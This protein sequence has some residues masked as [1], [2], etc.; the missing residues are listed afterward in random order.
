M[1]APEPLTKEQKRARKERREA[2]ARVAIAENAKAAVELTRNR[3]RFKAERLARES[4]AAPS[5][6]G[7]AA[8]TLVYSA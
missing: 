7:Q 1:K 8:R 6:K 4:T 5:T 2:D 3:E